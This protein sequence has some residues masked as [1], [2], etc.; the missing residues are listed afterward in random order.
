M[1]KVVFI[2]LRD[3][4]QNPQLRSNI[5][6]LSKRIMPDN[7]SPNPPLVIDVD[8]VFIAIFNPNESLPIKNAS[9]C[10]GNLIAAEDDWWRPMAKIPDGSYALFRSDENTVELVSDI[11]AS[12]TIWYVQTEDM[13]IASTSQRAIVFFLQDFRPNKEAFSWVL[14]SGTLGPGLSWDKTIQCLSGNA[15]LLLNRSSWKLSIKRQDN[16]FDPLNLSC[17]E[18]EEQLKNALEYVFEHLRLNYSKWV[19]PLS[20]GYDSRTI[21]L[22]LKNKQN[23]K[24]ITWGVKSSLNDKENDAYIARS[25]ARHFNLE[26]EYFTTDISNEPIEKIFNR[27]LVAGEGR[28][29]VVSGYMDGFKIW[30][31]L[32]ENKI[33]GILR[34]DHGYGDPIRT[35]PSFHP[36]R[37]CG[38]YLL[39]DYFKPRD[40]RR[41]DLEEQVWPEGL[42]RKEEEPLLT[43]YIRLYQEFHMPCKLAALSDLKLCYVEV[44]FPFLTRRMVEQVRKL[45]DSLRIRKRLHKKII[46]SISPK[47]GFAKRPAIANPANILR[48]Q[49]V[50]DFLYN[51][52]N[53]TYARTLL[54][55]KFIT[56]ILENLNGWHFAKSLKRILNAA[57]IKLLN[58][59][60]KMLQ[61]D[62]YVLALRAYMIC[63]MNQLLFEDSCVLKQK[64]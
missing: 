40:L 55:D 61:I 31:T 18:H 44:I 9:V 59:T 19:L 63:K 34:G 48:G 58:D 30:K 1:S 11:V 36:R 24:C 38:A 45:P 21:L 37:T 20:G 33:S 16:K 51:E 52:L 8:G 32:F 35:F 3:S 10:M 42:Q 43:W 53:T 17:K 14:S 4:R 56:H 15:R 25:L 22:M 54:S 50:R 7:I 27:F 57:A 41:F 2:C 5:E 47:I 13:F 60:V 28:N 39:S 12:R 49:Q 26:H 6:T 62:Y 23:L 64:R 46:H 29:S